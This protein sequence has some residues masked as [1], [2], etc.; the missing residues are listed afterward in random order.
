MIEVLNNDNFEDSKAEMTTLS[1]RTGRG[2]Q[3]KVGDAGTTDGAADP[4]WHLEDYI[5]RCRA[6]MDGL[7]FEAAAVDGL[8]SYIHD[9]HRVRYDICIRAWWTRRGAS[10]RNRAVRLSE[11]PY[12]DMSIAS[13]EEE[14]SYCQMLKNVMTSMGVM[15]LPSCENLTLWYLD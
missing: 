4:R 1:M 12:V 6:T 14:V 7:C 11:V 2:E 5:E 8:S 3:D 9:R 10:D 13:C 15:K